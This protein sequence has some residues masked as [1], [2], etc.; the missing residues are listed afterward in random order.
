MFCICSQ[1]GLTKSHY[2]QYAQELEGQDCFGGVG[3]PDLLI[4]T[5]GEKR[6]SNFL[7]WDSAYTE[8]FFTDVY[9]PDFEEVDL[10]AAIADYSR[11]NRRYGGR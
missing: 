10:M 2:M 11:R 7:L 6:L 9:W 1:S 4:R 3:D 5:S 8:L